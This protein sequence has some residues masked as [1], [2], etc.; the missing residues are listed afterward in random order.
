MATDYNITTFADLKLSSGT[1]SPKILI[2]DCIDLVAKT[3]EIPRA[4]ILSHARHADATLSRHKAM[5][6]ARRMLG[7]GLVR[8]G[9]TFFRDHTSVLHAIRKIEMMRAQNNT[10]S[11]HLEFLCKELETLASLR[12]NPP[13]NSYF[14][15]PR[16][17]H[18]YVYVM[19][20]IDGLAPIKIGISFDP[21][22][23]L[24]EFSMPTPL[25]LHYACQVQTAEIARK[26]EQ[27]ALR[28]FA[29][30]RL[31]GEWVQCTAAEAISVI[32]RYAEAHE[33]FFSARGKTDHT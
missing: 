28:K 15:P 23:R 31:Q 19:G 11:A 5:W 26:I 13:P 33:E 6:L 16:D 1:L 3:D 10:F 7:Y 29:A 24:L 25:K 2:A 32:S 18:Y 14:S 20:R 8:I 17:R 9:R 21:N 30:E 22:R 4:L 27:L 12:D